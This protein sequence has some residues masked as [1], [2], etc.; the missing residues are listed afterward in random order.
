MLLNDTPIFAI[1]DDTISEK[2]KPSSNAENTI[3][4]ASFHRSHLKGKQVY[5]HQLL[6]AMLSDGK[7][8]LPYSISRYEKVKK[9]KYKW[10]VK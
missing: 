2:T 1:Y 8:V 3:Q 5:G 10:F 6:T 4:E 9:A 7:K